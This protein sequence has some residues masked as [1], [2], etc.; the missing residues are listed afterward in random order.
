[1]LEVHGLLSS[2]EAGLV[3]V[4]LAWPSLCLLAG[5]QLGQTWSALETL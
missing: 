3:S 4:G 5:D 1:M 2:P